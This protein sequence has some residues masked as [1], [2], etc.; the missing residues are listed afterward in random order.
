VAR[1]REIARD[2]GTEVVDVVFNN[3]VRGQG[4]VNALQFKKMIGGRKVAAPPTLFEAFTGELAGSAR[5]VMP[6]VGV[7]EG[8]G[9][10]V[11][12]GA[13]AVERRRAA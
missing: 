12:E 9:E 6:V 8:A 10:G 5:P 11:E 13:R 2:R 1:A 4:V 3:H 7:G